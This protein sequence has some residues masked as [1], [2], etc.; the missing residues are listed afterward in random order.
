MLTL[1]RH[2]N[3]P[4]YQKQVGSKLLYA[5]H[6]YH[7]HPHDVEIRFTFLADETNFRYQL[8]CYYDGQPLSLSEQKPCY[9]A[10]LLTVCPLTGNG[11]VLLSAY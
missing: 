3:L 7:V 2:H 9:R 11:A 4:L 10:D 8:Q 5:H 1:I 6:A